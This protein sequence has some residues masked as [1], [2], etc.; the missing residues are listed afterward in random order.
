MSDEQA[1][2]ADEDEHREEEELHQKL[3]ERRELIASAN[4][5][6]RVC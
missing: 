2:D 3:I 5:R 4:S 6:R 1:I